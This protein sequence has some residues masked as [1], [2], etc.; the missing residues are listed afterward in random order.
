MV[1]ADILPG[2]AREVVVRDFEDTNCVLIV[3]FIN[4]NVD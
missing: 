3:Q 2:A 1:G 4:E